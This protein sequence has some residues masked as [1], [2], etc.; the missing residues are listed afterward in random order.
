MKMIG[1]C[2]RVF[3]ISMI[4]FDDLQFEMD[5]VGF[6]MVHRTHNSHEERNDAQRRKAVFTIRQ[7]NVQNV[8]KAAVTFMS[9]DTSVHRCEL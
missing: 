3:P 4:P 2:M 1:S 9:A 8:N 7:E 6:S 5:G